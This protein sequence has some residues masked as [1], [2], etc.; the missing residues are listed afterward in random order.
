MKATTE[1]LVEQLCL[2]YTALESRVYQLELTNEKQN[3]CTYSE[4][5]VI[6]EGGCCRFVEKKK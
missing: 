2:N 5:S 1:E 3:K 6:Q 4:Y